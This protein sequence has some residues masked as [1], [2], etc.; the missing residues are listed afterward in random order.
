MVLS[1][2]SVIIQFE[3]KIVFKIKQKNFKM[4]SVIIDLNVTL[5]G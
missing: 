5:L 1:L 4:K 3:K 2:F